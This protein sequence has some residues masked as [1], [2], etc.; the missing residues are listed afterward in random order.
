MKI[1][2]SRNCQSPTRIALLAFTG[3]RDAND[4]DDV[5]RLLSPRSPGGADDD[6]D[7]LADEMERRKSMALEDG[8]VKD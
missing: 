8:N 7:G 5:S 6:S 1:S 3:A 4:L 2:D